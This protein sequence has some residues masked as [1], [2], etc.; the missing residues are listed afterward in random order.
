MNQKVAG[1]LIMRLSYLLLQMHHEGLRA[2]ML[3]TEQAL[4]KHL[5]SSQFQLH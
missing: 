5:G 1:H 2:L 3:F 4:I